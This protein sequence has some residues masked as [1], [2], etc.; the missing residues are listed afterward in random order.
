MTLRDKLKLVSSHVPSDKA[1]HA[2]VA[3]GF[4]QPKAE[5]TA[6]KLPTVPA[7]P[8]EPDAATLD[9]EVGNMEKEEVPEL[10]AACAA[11]KE[12]RK[13][14]EDAILSKNPAADMADAAFEQHV[15]NVFQEKGKTPVVSLDAVFQLW[16]N[17]EQKGGNEKELTTLAVQFD[18][19]RAQVQSWS[20]APQPVPQEALLTLDGSAPD[21]KAATGGRPAI[22]DTQVRAQVDKVGEE[23]RDAADKA[24]QRPNDEPPRSAPVS[25]QTTLD[26]DLT[27]AAEELMGQ[28]Q[29]KSGWSW[30]LGAIIAA[31]FILGLLAMYIYPRMSG[32]TDGENITQV[33]DVAAEPSSGRHHVTTPLLKKVNAAWPGASGDVTC[34][35]PDP[36]KADKN[37]PSVDCVDHETNTSKV[38]VNPERKAKD[39]KTCYD[40]TACWINIP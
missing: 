30:R 14:F 36:A 35:R 25:R 37:K 8:K 18:L 3:E 17:C 2:V 12:A 34:W 10:V 31:G 11:A 38:I 40:V 29:K 21:I 9:Q 22:S 4:P 33:T 5:G 7:P 15:H 39:G 16:C 1:I 28:K 32:K 23:A 20:A 27:E 24:A 26:D 13:L 19:L 6:S